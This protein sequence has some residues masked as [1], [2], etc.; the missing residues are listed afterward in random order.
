MFY[1]I[2]ATPDEQKYLDMMNTNIRLSDG[3]RVDYYKRQDNILNYPIYSNDMKDKLKKYFEKNAQLKFLCNKFYIKLKNRLKK[4]AN[5]TDIYCNDIDDVKELIVIQRKD[6]IW[7]FVPEQLKDIIDSALNYSSY[8]MPDPKYPKNP[9]TNQEFNIFEM[10][11]IFKKLKMLHKTS[12]NIELFNKYK[13]D[14]DLFNRYCFK[15]LK[16][17]SIHR[18]VNSWNA[19]EEDFLHNML[20]IYETERYRLGG[21]CKDCLLEIVKKSPEMFRLVKKLIIHNYIDYNEQIY[22][23]YINALINM[24]GEYIKKNTC[25]HTKPQKLEQIA[26]DTLEFRVGTN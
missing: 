18:V 3:E 22:T 21:I 5:D 17:D 24:Y 16:Q 19:E 14:I 23:N 4:F 6:F 20:D 9:Y 26:I 15:I 12:I 11:N 13:F 1:L 7:R 10:Y 25:S 2:K 8:L